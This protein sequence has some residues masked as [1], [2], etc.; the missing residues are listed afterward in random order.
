MT[1]YLQKILALKT[2]HQGTRKSLNILQDLTKE[3][4]INREEYRKLYPTTETPPKFYGL[5]KMH[6]VNNP[7][8]LIVSSVGTITYNCAKHLAD[9]LSP[10]VC[11]TRHHVANSDFTDHITKEH[12]EEDEELRS[13]N[14]TALF[15]PS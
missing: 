2:P 11:K 14:V 9:I 5:P 3:G 7:L 8:R 12:V 1:C 15:K 13:Y 4:G 10:V 6:K